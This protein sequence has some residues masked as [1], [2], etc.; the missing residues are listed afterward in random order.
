[1]PPS[2]IN[3]PMLAGTGAELFDIVIRMD[4]LGAFAYE[5]KNCVEIPLGRQKLK[6]LSLERILVSKIAANRPKDKLTIPVLRDA[7]AATQSI[8]RR[9]KKK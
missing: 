6:V 4:G 5:I 1:M 7:L 3:P 9:A 2:A 8:K